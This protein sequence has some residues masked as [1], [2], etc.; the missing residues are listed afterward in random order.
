MINKVTTTSDK[1]DADNNPIE[2]VSKNKVVPLTD[3]MKTPQKSDPDAEK[4]LSPSPTKSMP[5]PTKK[6]TPTPNTL[7]ELKEVD[8]GDKKMGCCA[9]MNKKV[10][11]HEFLDL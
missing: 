7:I 4:S 2:R 8:D 6:S 1:K 5:S 10:L 9:R 3:D 11:N